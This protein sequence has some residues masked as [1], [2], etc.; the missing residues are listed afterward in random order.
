[1]GSTRLPG[2]VL[3]DDRRPAARR[4][5][6]WRRWQ[7]SPS[8]TAIVVATTTEPRGR[9][10]VDVLV[11]RRLA[12][13][14][15]PD[16]RRPDPLLGGRRAVRARRRRPRDGRQPVRRSGRGRGPGRARLIDG[17]FDYVGHGRL[18]ARDRRR[19]GRGP[20]ALETAYRRGDRCRRARAR[21]ALPVRTA[22]ALPDRVARRRPTP[23][24]PG[25]F[26]VDTAEDLAFARAHRRPARRRGDRPAS[27]ALRADPGRRAGAA[28]PEPRRPPEDLAGGRAMNV[29]R[30][31]DRPVGD[32]APVYIIAE[33]GSNHDRDLAQAQAADRG[34]RRGRRRRGQVPDLPGRPD[35]RRDA[36]PGQVPRRHPAAGQDDVRPVPR[37]RAAPRVACRA[38]EPTP[39]PC[40]LDFLSTPVRPSRRSTCSTASAS[41][42]SRSRPTSS[43]TCP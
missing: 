16:P 15:R 17:G 23:P 39:R 9:R 18:A 31:G 40:G 33:A 4:S 24:P 14:S 36:D 20:S 8:S 1:M 27:T 29:V 32:G 13:P 6:R 26:T 19:G 3:A 30:I 7:P 21:D 2:K 25:R 41:R 22:G 43:G 37:A 10:L 5:G 38:Q 35:R 42:P 11:E 28:R 12:R 34:R